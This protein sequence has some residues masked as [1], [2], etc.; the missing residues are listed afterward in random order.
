MRSS[1]SQPLATS[2]TRQTSSSAARISTALLEQFEPGGGQMGTLAAPVEDQDV[3]LVFEPAHGVGE[4][5]GHLAQFGGRRGKAAAPGDRV[6][7]SQRIEREGHVQ[8]L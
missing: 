8:N 5:G 1:T 2:L 6:Q 4:R 7:D 3:E